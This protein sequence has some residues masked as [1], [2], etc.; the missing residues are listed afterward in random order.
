MAQIADR[1]PTDIVF[2]KRGVQ[3]RDLFVTTQELAQDRLSGEF[4]TKMNSMA[5][6]INSVATIMD[7]QAYTVNEDKNLTKVYRDDAQLFRN[8]AVAARDTI[9]GYVVPTNATL[10]PD[11][12]NALVDSHRLENF[13][14]FNF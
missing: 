2:G 3:T 6:D 13:L 4:A 1:L 5:A 14:G 9:F 8:D 10:T 12:I 7:S 11:A